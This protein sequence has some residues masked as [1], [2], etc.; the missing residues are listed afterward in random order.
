[1]REYKTGQRAPRSGIYLFSRYVEGQHPRPTA[2]ELRI[3]LSAGEV[4]PPIRSQ[5]AAAWWEA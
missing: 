5:N 3:H 4:F 2:Q 1:M